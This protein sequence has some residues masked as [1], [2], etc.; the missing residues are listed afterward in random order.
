MANQEQPQRG[1]QPYENEPLLRIVRLWILEQESVFV[2]E[3]CLACS[4]DTPCFRSFDR[5]FWGS[6]EKC[7]AQPRTTM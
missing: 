2:K 1:N 3:D 7:V 6:Q 5:A 4:N